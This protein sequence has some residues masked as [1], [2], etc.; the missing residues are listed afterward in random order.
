[1]SCILGIFTK[2]KMQ[3][4]FMES[5]QMKKELSK[6]EKKSNPE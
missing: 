6:E 3:I 4:L 1:M 5:M 2:W